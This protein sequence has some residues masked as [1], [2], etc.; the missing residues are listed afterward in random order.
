MEPITEKMRKVEEEKRRIEAEKQ[1]RMEKEIRERIA[2]VSQN[3]FF[4]SDTIK[5]NL[6]RGNKSITDEEIEEFINSYQ[7]NEDM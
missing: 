7:N 2:Y 1:Q 3:V 4:F 5:E 6:V